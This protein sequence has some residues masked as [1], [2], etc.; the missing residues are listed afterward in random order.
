MIDDGRPYLDYVFPA[1]ANGKQ[2]EWN[3]SKYRTADR[4]LGDVVEGLMKEV[5][6]IENAQRNKGS[7]YAL[8]KGQMTSIQRKKT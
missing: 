4:A 7:A 8:V 5:Q 6:S 1:D 2:W 3:R